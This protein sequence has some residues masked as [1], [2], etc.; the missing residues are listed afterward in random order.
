MSTHYRAL[1]PEQVDALNESFA[2]Y[3]HVAVYDLTDGR[4][5]VLEIQ[6]G[7]DEEAA[8]LRLRNAGI[9]D[10][11]ATVREI[12]PQ[13]LAPTLYDTFASF[14]AV[15]VGQSGDGPLPESTPSYDLLIGAGIETVGQA[16]AA[17][18]DGLTAIS[19]I[20]TAT[21]TKIL[22][23]LPVPGVIVHVN[24]PDREG[25]PG[26]SLG[27]DPEAIDAELV[28]HEFS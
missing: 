13:R 28:P 6:D 11:G 4:E 27:T 8:L 9:S 12:G 16:R 3:V 24:G 23:S 21:A 10:E 22:A 5:L 2:R 19:G 26:T 1:T 7:A 17:G 15:K 25:L 20:G 18:M 14:G